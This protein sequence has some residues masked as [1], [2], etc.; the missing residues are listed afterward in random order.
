MLEQQPASRP[1]DI[2]AAI[3][4][5]NE[6]PLLREDPITRR[7]LEEGIGAN[8]KPI[9]DLAHFVEA[10]GAFLELESAA[11]RLRKAR[12]LNPEILNAIVVSS[13]KPEV[14]KYIN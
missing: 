4:L 7:A 2:D 5:I 3:A 1:Q 9:T 10:R 6:Q 8:G 12:G 11:N 14:E 13:V